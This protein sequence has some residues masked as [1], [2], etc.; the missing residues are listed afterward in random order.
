MDNNNIPLGLKTQ[1]QIPL[2]VKEY[3]TS[4][5][6]L[7][8]LGQNNQLA[9]TYVKGL[10]VYCIEEGTRWEWKEVE[11]GLENTGLISEDFTYPSGHIAFGINYSEKVYNF[12]QV[13]NFNIELPDGSETKLTEGT[14]ITIIGTGTILNPYEISSS[15]ETSETYIEEGDNIIITGNGTIETPY[16]INTNLEDLGIVKTI[17]DEV[18][19]PNQSLSIINNEITGKVLAT[20]EYVDSVIPTSNDGSETK[21]NAG[22]NITIT[23]EGTVLEPYEINAVDQNSTTYINPG[24][25]VEITGNGAI[26]NPYIINATGGSGS[27][28]TNLSYSPSSTNGIIS[29]DTGTDATI[30]LADL[31]NA[32]LLSPSEKLEIS[33]ALQPGDITQYT[34]EQSQDA[35]GTILT[36]SSTIDLVY[37]DITPSISADVKLNS[38]NATHLADNINISEFNNDLNY[39]DIDY[40]NDGLDTKLNISDMPANLTLYPT[41]TASD[42]SGYVVL[43]KDIHDPR[44]NSTAVDVSTPAITGTAQLISQRISDAGV[45]TGN[46]GIFNVTTYGNIRKLSGSGTAQFYFQVYHR[47]SAGTETLICTSSISSEVVN[48]SYA[49][50]SASGI[51]DNGAFDSTDRIVIKSY[52]NRIAGGS[53]PVYQFQFGGTAPVRTV[54]PVP[55]NVLAG[56]YEIKSNKQ[57]SLVVDG[58]GQ[59]YPTV[60]AVNLAVAEVTP[61]MFGAVGDGVSDDAPEI[62]DAIDFLET[63]G[64]ALRLKSGSTYRINS[65]I[66]LPS[67][68]TVIGYGSKVELGAN[69]VQMFVTKGFV[70][71]ARTENI[72]FLGGTYDGGSYGGAPLTAF[73]FIFHKSDRIIIKDI[74][75]N[76]LNSAHYM[77]VL[78]DTR[79]VIIS[80]CNFITAKDGVHLMGK[81]Y[82]TK[83]ENIYGVTG[84]DLIAVTTRDYPGIDF[85]EG[86]VQ[87]LYIKNIVCENETR[88]VLLGNVEHTIKDVFIENIEQLGSGALLNVGDAGTTDTTVLVDNLNIKN[89]KGGNILLRHRNMG[90]VNIENVDSQVYVG[91]ENGDIY[92]GGGTGLSNIDHLKIDKGNELYMEDYVDISRNIE[93]SNMTG[94]L[95]IGG[96]TDRFSISNS[97]ILGDYNL[98]IFQGLLKYGLISNC[99]FK[100]TFTGNDAVLFFTDTIEKLLIENSEL[101][102]GST[103]SPIIL[104]NDSNSIIKNLTYSNSK[105]SQCSRI[106]NTF[107]SGT[108][109][110]IVNLVNSE[111]DNVS[112]LIEDG[113]AVNFIINYNN[114]RITNA[115]NAVFRFYAT[116]NIKIYGD[117]WVSNQ[118]TFASGTTNIDCY[119]QD[120]P[121]DVSLV[122]ITFGGRALNINESLAVGIGSCASN[123][124]GWYN[125]M[126]GA[127]LQPITPSKIKITTTP[128]SS[129]G[130]YSF[131]TYN[132]A[133][134]EVEQVASD[135]KQNTLVAGTGI[136]IDNT[137][138]DSPIISSTGG[139]V[140][141]AFTP[142]TYSSTISRAHDAENP[143]IEIT[144]SGNLN[145]TVTGTV[146]GDS[147][148]VNIYSSASETIVVNG[149]K[150]L[151]LIGDGSSQMIPIYFI[152]STDGIR[153]YD[154]R[155][156]T[157]SLVDTSNL[158]ESVGTTLWHDYV[159]S[160]TGTVTSSGT[161]WTGTG[162]SLTNNMVGAKLFI[163][164]EFLI[165]D[166][167][168]TGAQTFT[169]TT[170]L[171]SN[172]TNSIFEIKY[173]AYKINS[174]GT[175]EFFDAIDGT[176]R[177]L[178]TNDGT[179]ETNGLV[180]ARNGNVTVN[181]NV[182][183]HDQIEL[184]QNN[185]NTPTFGN[186]VVYTLATL[187]TFASNQ[188]IYASISDALNPSSGKIVV[189]GGTTNTSVYWNGTNWIALTGGAEISQTI[190]NGVTT[191]AP[192]QDAVFDAMALK[193]DKNGTIFTG[194]V[195]VTGANFKTNGN[196]VFTSGNG[197]VAPNNGGITFQADNPIA[198]GWISNTNIKATFYKTTVYTVATLP[199]TG[200]ITGTYT[201]V[202]DALTPTYLTPVVGGGAIV[203]PVFYDGTNW[204]CH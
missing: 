27:G 58:T 9:Y 136:E 181:G 124:A 145:L 127:G 74:N 92:Y 106:Y 19:A 148:M 96:T 91:R 170:A 158:A 60:D 133:T 61:E 39:V 113:S 53:D 18:I 90:Y 76:S 175:Q 182:F 14:N 162:T 32:G 17:N 20:K 126:T 194:E 25:N 118:N 89:A 63:K 38:I 75:F 26:D 59:K 177:E 47:D 103:N 198:P 66:I 134:D 50:F 140:D 56:E 68:I 174:D 169:T 43:V 7:S 28:A 144:L 12:F 110:T 31:S 116:Q 128:T 180:A 13:L 187:P 195:E 132:A 141:T 36:D 83:I 130:S 5:L 199:I 176:R 107:F 188:R 204:V 87:G 146:N 30:P 2:D 81:N 72:T 115:I 154:G 167:V 16:V 138:P 98:I 122:N 33:T 143:N 165:I 82:N 79:D 119:A 168:N 163:G 123:W 153:W 23:G 152:H 49:E 171:D 24:T 35:V 196:L 189:G 78:A 161:N 11:S 151:S 166:T 93:L 192:S 150:G 97:K 88:A 120:L 77:V 104:G 164:S 112:R 48:G 131:L 62:Q 156:S 135:T 41:T 100:S 111:F 203:C 114:I 173:K 69:S 101:Q 108:G 109:T 52:A 125:I 45:L 73:R 185:V 85:E 193:A 40:V 178:L 21:L 34:D 184:Y 183:T 86:D 99:V 94:R 202:S 51:W 190:I 8:N 46:P 129:A 95:S 22:N 54:L 191:S 157:G 84:D 37:N 117:G 1:T 200:V 179:K 71:G 15:F 70:S 102:A 121:I 6:T 172:V 149:L 139:S 137:D 201:T 4:E 29:S 55:F 64:G 105:I 67:N 44:Y 186:R 10:I 57:N 42:V 65:T 159:G 80:D 197:I 142:V 155:E 3:S 160:S 147:G